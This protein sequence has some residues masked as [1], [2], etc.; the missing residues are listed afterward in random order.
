MAASDLRQKLARA[1]AQVANIKEK[2][3]E[4]M[5]T[6]KCAVE[7]VGT[8]FGFGYLRGRMT[9]PADP[10]SFSVMGVEPDLL[11]GVALHA[12]G[13]L[14][15]FGK[16]SEDAHNVANGALSSYAVTKGVEIG[17]DARAESEG[18]AGVGAIRQM[19]GAPA[20]IGSRHSQVNLAEQMAG[21]GAAHSPAGA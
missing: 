10:E 18:T 12:V 2:A 13:F 8:A 9:D 16:Y 20:Q 15:G 11:A 19:S 17:V 5:Q 4:T 21:A 6:A 14:G 3:E 1:K 7:T